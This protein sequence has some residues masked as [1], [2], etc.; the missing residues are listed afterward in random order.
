[1]ANLTRNQEQ[2]LRDAFDLFDRNRSGDISKKEL[3]KVLKTL[4]IKANEKEL[5]ALI[6]QM[7]ADGSGKIDF[8][9]FKAVMGNKYFSRHSTANLEAAFSSFDSDGNGFLTID[10]LQNVMSRMGRHMTLSEIKAM[11]Q[12]LDTNKDGKISFNEFA[13]LFD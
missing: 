7:D 9:E 10:E 1:M 6:N 3:K 8:N 4:G 13:K 12:S 2:Q 11:V 5:Q